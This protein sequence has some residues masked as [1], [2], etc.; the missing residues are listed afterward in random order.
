MPTLA[1]TLKANNQLLSTSAE[2]SKTLQQMPGQGN[3]SPLAAAV[4]GA[5]P[6]SAKM[7]GTPNN[8]QRIQ[9]NTTTADAQRTQKDVGPSQVAVDKRS[10]LQQISPL[11]N[12]PQALKSSV[13]QVLAG[14]GTQAPQVDVDD[15]ILTASITSGL[16]PDVV[17][18][19]AQKALNGQATQ[20]ELAQLASALGMSPNASAQEI[21]NK[22]QSLSKQG[23]LGSSIAAGLPDEMTLAQLSPD[24]MLAQGLNL[25][26]ISQSLGVTEGEL[27]GMSLGDIR[28]R[29][30]SIG[31]KDYAEVEKLQAVANDIN[32]SSA[33]R[34]EAIKRLRELGSSGVRA[35]EAD[36]QKLEDTL[37]ED[38]MVS[39]GDEQVPLSEVLSDESLSAA[40]KAYLDDPEYAA[41]LKA[42]QPEFAAFIDNNR[43][44][45]EEA[46][47]K[48]SA[49]STQL[50]NTQLANSKLKTP[51][52]G[53][54][55][56][57]DF[58]QLIMPGYNQLSGTASTPPAIYSILSD[59]SGKYTAEY[60]SSL[61][62]TLSSMASRNP[63]LTKELSNLSP[64]ELANYGLNTQEGLANYS[65]YVSEFDSVQ[66]AGS[67]EELLERLFGTEDEMQKLVNQAHMFNESGFG[68]TDSQLLSIL[69]DNGDGKVDSPEEV[70]ARLAQL[71]PSASPSTLIKGNQLPSA[72]RMLD[73]LQSKVEESKQGLY[74]R[75]LPYLSD[76]KLDKR[77]A[78][79]LAKNTSSLSELVSLRDAIAKS[80]LTVNTSTKTGNLIQQ[81][82][83][84][85]TLNQVID[86]KATQQVNDELASK[87]VD[88][89]SLVEAPI[90]TDV[91]KVNLFSPLKFRE[92]T[93]QL[94]SGL[95]TTQAK[96]AEVKRLRETVTDALTGKKYDDI[97]SQLSAKEKG[98]KEA[99]AS[100]SGVPKSTTM[101]STTSSQRS[102]SN[103][104][105]NTQ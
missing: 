83:P 94:S 44:V 103:I 85:Q 42:Q 53:I 17:K 56:S 55:L 97:I 105:P 92:R 15:S 41:L 88:V 96:L 33:E 64:Q 35:V 54:T 8:T 57:E 63:E 77:E 75:V 69:D 46:A 99:L 22:V 73:E 13:G 40:V 100:H 38:P 30:N 90:P 65:K 52:D 76:G 39:L 14:A 2:G 16:S 7:S 80:G 89:K 31:S 24:E 101:S 67:D 29:I 81:F 20:Q 25:T 62:G 68:N 91:I 49:T 82:G 43:K 66:N 102:S 78:E 34:N 74:G 37:A 26:E 9:T 19:L 50:A 93:E 84:V 58:M 36:Y 70:R 12:V 4:S 21:Q 104:S 98:W 71:Y 51:S 45:M 32:R 23:S 3:D 95:Q 47:A 27:Q 72:S 6:H 11:E 5:N 1:E 28:S 48:L 60:K 10:Q 59:N 79:D 86:A 61:A 18:P 87:G